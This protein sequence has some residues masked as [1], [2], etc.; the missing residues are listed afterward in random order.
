MTDV[1]K[2][3]IQV[4]STPAL[5]AA[6]NLAALD[7]AAGRVVKQAKNLKQAKLGTTAKTGGAAFS[8][9]SKP[10]EQAITDLTNFGKSLDS[11]AISIG[12]LK[13]SVGDVGTDFEKV[14]EAVR[15][16]SSDEQ[17]TA[18][19]TVVGRI[20]RFGEAARKAVPGLKGA[21]KMA[22]A[23]KT[24]T[25]GIARRLGSIN[26][27]FEELATSTEGSRKGLASNARLAG[28]AATRFEKLQEQVKQSAGSMKNLEKALNSTTPAGK[29]AAGS[30]RE[31]G[32]SSLRANGF[33][34][35]FATGLGLVSGGFALATGLKGFVKALADFEF[36]AAKTAAVTIRMGTAFDVAAQQQQQLA[37]QARELGASTRF[38]AVQAAEAQFFLARAGFDANEVLAA[39]PATL[40]IAAAG[41]IELG[42]AADIASN[43]L[44]Q[45]SL[46]T[47][48]LTDVGDAL[49]FTANNANTSVEQM[50]Q[51]LNYA[52]P[53]AASL[54]VTVNEA[55]AAIG[56][57]GNAGIQGSLAGT[58]FRGI[59]VSLLS[60]SREA[61]EELDKLGARLGGAREQF[62][63]ASLGIKDV[64]IN[65][66]EAT[67]AAPDASESLAKIFNRRNVSG[68]LALSKNVEDFVDLLNGLDSD[69]GSAKK[70]ADFVD[71]T[72]LGAILRLKS[73]AVEL[74]L[75]M[76]QDGIGKS[77]RDF[78]DNF[79]E[80]L[81]VLAGSPAILQSNIAAATKFAEGIRLAIDAIKGLVVGGLVAG[82][83][84]SLGSLTLQLSKAAKGATVLQNVI[85]GSRASFGKAKDAYSAF[86][87]RTRSSTVA[88]GSF[89]GT[90]TKVAKGVLPALAV[91]LRGVGAAMGVLAGPVGA[92]IG[93]LAAFGPSLIKSKST[94]AGLDDISNAF[95]RTA[96]A[97]EA[98]RRRVEAFGEQGSR[99]DDFRERVAAVGDADLGKGVEGTVKALPSLI[100]SLS[101][102]SRALTDFR[103]SARGV[104][105][106]SA[107]LGT[108]LFDLLNA[109][110]RG[111][112][113]GINGV[114][115][116]LTKVA[117]ASGDAEALKQVRDLIAEL[118]IAAD[119]L[120][121][122]L[123]LAILNDPDRQ[124]K[125]I[126][127]VERRAERAA[128]VLRDIQGGSVLAPID[129]REVEDADATLARLTG[130][131]Q[132]AAAQVLRLEVAADLDIDVEDLPQNVNEAIANAVSEV[133]PAGGAR[134][135]ALEVGI[136]PTLIGAKGG[137]TLDK[138]VVELVETIRA[139]TG[140]LEIVPVRSI[141][142]EVKKLEELF[143]TAR[144]LATKTSAD[145]VKREQELTRQG[146]IRAKLIKLGEEQDATAQ[147][148]L[149]TAKRLAG[150][151][152]LEK[153]RELALIDLER[154][155]AEA[156][157]ETLYAVSETG[158]VTRQI[159]GDQVKSNVLAKF[160]LAISERNLAATKK[161]AEQAARLEARIGARVNDEVA[162]NDELRR[163]LGIATELTE[164]E[165]VRAQVA[166]ELSKV[167]IK[168]SAT[169]L[170]LT[171]ALSA[172]FTEIARQRRIAAAGKEV[173]GIVKQNESLREQI[174]EIRGIKD[175]T[176]QL[177]AVEAARQLLLDT[178]LKENNSQFD[179]YLDRLAAAIL[180]NR[181]LKDELFNAEGDSFIAERTKEVE[182]LEKQVED[183]GQLSPQSR[184]LFA[185]QDQ[186]RGEDQAFID[187]LAELEGKADAANASLAALN[188]TAK[189]TT[190]VGDF[191]EFLTS[192]REQTEA[193]KIQAGLISELSVE[194]ERNRAIR[195]NNLVLSQD[196][197]T[198]LDEEIVKRREAQVALEDYNK[199]QQIDA[200]VQQQQQQL[201]KG[202]TDVALGAKTAEE[203]MLG[204]VNQ[205]LAAIVQAQIFK[206][207]GPLFGGA[208]GLGSIIG[209]GIAPGVGSYRGNVFTN[210]T[211]DN[212]YYR[213]GVPYLDQLP[214]IGS[215]PAAFRGADGSLNTLREGGS[216]EAIL[217][218]DRDGSGRLGVRMTGGSVGGNSTVNTTNNTTVQNFNLSTP[219]DTFGLTDRQ[220]ERR[221]ARF[222]RR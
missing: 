169:L 67:A 206:A 48:Q 25:K 166:R 156:K 87:L 153:Q 141:D 74:A 70:V 207:L 4:D 119:D 171:A 36:Q 124:V 30:I 15:K 165:R 42:R 167:Q 98:A 180:K 198:T 89:S 117:E 37:V 95:D 120:E 196:Q 31:V 199:Q 71:D 26:G 22:A 211:V 106:D 205:L 134:R 163:R 195:D 168:D 43:V 113:F 142:P 149:I 203:A 135:Q 129:L 59:L 50:A 27:K 44:Q 5:K 197:I 65:L 62:D 173:E 136:T 107:V 6:E 154:Q 68:A 172:S 96:Q 20:E 24:N 38:T 138:Q 76:G 77:L 17:G 218:L 82:L 128:K 178:G 175:A 155:V 55:T 170:A 210:G 131:V 109:D 69:L 162:A 125:Q 184:A 190:K 100:Q 2:L 200:A 122:S 105:R 61:G 92:V 114:A 23:L 103:Q 127:R 202:L 11:Q 57:L 160:A 13:K 91:G 104:N 56:A 179:K 47:S 110:G 93:L 52:G 183:G 126:E 33:V 214:K 185:A 115:F 111:A 222:N 188:Q 221:M 97:A 21:A 217:P 174:N 144:K 193:I 215:I 177:S 204:F 58:N 78:V 79:S 90:A 108:E 220:R 73:A 146:D 39:T 66:R 157:G 140:T 150:L 182:R 14:A 51:A 9:I 94:V 213:G 84:S 112:A 116:A 60:P 46:N 121:R 41:Y 75:E 123:D 3:Q 130:R 72:L 63:V 101:S 194:E 158:E 192:F 1:A 34:R 99:L 83:A 164:Q 133:F 147:E 102:A 28:Q 10:V 64:L 8:A 159:I 189:E 35:Q 139:S 181:E 12:N 209:G 118:G 148:E 137:F 88:M 145:A 7:K 18:L 132:D 80:G 40:D 212:Q 201:A 186:G 216:S 191:G 19:D 187:Q 151:G 54:G 152:E 45:F 86:L 32:F 53:F 219:E 143:D 49:V 29:R 161:D 85:L 208:G 176:D 81:R 16:L